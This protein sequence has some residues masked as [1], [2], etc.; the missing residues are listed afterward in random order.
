[1][2]THQ[3]WNF[4]GIAIVLPIVLGILIHFSTIISAFGLIRE[5]PETGE[6]ISITNTIMEVL[7]S[8]LVTFCTFL[9]NYFIVKPFD[10]SRQITTKLIL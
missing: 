3:I 7:V 6:S 5:N 4:I 2:K 10:N 9:M 8:S 1:M